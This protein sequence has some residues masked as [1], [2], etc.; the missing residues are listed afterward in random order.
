MKTIRINDT[1]FGKLQVVQ[2]RMIEATQEQWNVSEIID[3]ALS[4]LLETEIIDKHIE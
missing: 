4:A 3:A 2:Q 1:V